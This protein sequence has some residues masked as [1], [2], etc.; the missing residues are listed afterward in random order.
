[1]MQRKE[2]VDRESWAY[3]LLFEFKLYHI[4]FWLVYHFSFWMLASGGDYSLLT[5]P[6][7]V[8]V[9]F[10]VVFQAIAVYFNLYY[11]MPRL[12][13]R[14]R[15]TQYLAAF[16]STVILTSL[17]IIPGYYASAWFAG[18]PFIE[19]FQHDPNDYFYFFKTIT[20][21][22]T[23]ASSTLG[24][25]VKLAKNW[26]NTRKRQQ[27]LERE[28]LETE[29]KFL[30]SQ[31]NPHFLFNTINSIFILISKD[32]AMAL[33][34]LAKFSDLLRYQLY[35]CN[36]HH[37][38]LAQELSY[39]NSYIELQR[40]RHDHDNLQMDVVIRSSETDE[41]LIAPFVLLP[42]IENA[43]KHVSKEKGRN[44][45]IRISIGAEDK[46]LE[47]TVE[48]TM[49]TDASREAVKGGGIGLA[50][51]RRRL[52]LLYRDNHVLH[53]GG[54]GERYLAQLE[55]ELSRAKVRTEIM[56]GA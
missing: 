55:L 11:L 54:D 3:R 47:M 7:I 38:P 37:I 32:P 4:P 16:L 43:F 20:F 56:A 52:D 26:L 23:L 5:S 39:I 22:S 18:R 34:S 29:L 13:E 17:L 28:K 42:F 9:L 10:Y 51:V 31:I 33:E 41:L 2:F 30:K 27:E 36:E 15:Y 35:E 25:S 19:M 44:N 50:N 49:A 45:A 53:V 46:I 6:Y 48:N 8:K 40:L 1:M 12:L 21:P 24:M 14:G